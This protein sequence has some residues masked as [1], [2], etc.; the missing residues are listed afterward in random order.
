M[1]IKKGDTVFVRTGQYKGKTG[2][3]LFVDVKKNVLLVEGINMK[4]KHQRPSQKNPKG[5]VITMENPIQISNVALYNSSLSAPTK[6][7]SREIDEGGKK[8]KIRICLKTGE[9]I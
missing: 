3:V 4:K 2:R 6:F 8:R 9:E 1:R 5:G 7:S